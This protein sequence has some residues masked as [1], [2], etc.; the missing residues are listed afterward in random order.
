[1]A[2]GF[3]FDTNKC[4]GCRACHVACKDLHDLNVGPILRKVRAFEVGTFPNVDGFRYSGS[5]Y[6]CANASCVEICPTGAMNYAADG[7]VQLDAAVCLNCRVCAIVCPYDAPQ[8]DEDRD[9]M[10][11]CD[12][13][14]DLRAAGKNPFCVDA[15]V[16]RCLEF[17]NMDELR[18]KHG[19]GLV[20]ELPALPR[21][22]AEP[23]VLIKAKQ[24]ALS[25]DFVEVEI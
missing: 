12:S 8:M 21:G 19:P 23:R 14:K 7:T 5:C 10:A 13:C 17:G 22:A 1:M 20:T 4:I 16:M 9:I 18:A 3:Y 25:V 24:C 15:C 6:H 2:L 11:K